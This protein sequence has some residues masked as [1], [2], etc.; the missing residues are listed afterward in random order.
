MLD[1]EIGALGGIHASRLGAY[2]IATRGQ[3]RELR[4]VRVQVDAIQ[5]V[6]THDRRYSV[7]RFRSGIGP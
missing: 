3:R 6:G 2:D 1:R 5:D 7:S 4:Q